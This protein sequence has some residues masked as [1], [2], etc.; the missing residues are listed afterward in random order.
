MGFGLAMPKPMT[1]IKYIED[2]YKNIEDRIARIRR[3]S[4]V[5]I[6][7]VGDVEPNELRT[8]IRRHINARGGIYEMHA[9]TV[10]NVRGF[11]VHCVER[12]PGRSVPAPRKNT[13]MA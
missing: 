6:P 9:G 4:F 8:I 10:K 5:F 1:R 7:C 11:W 2:Q 12:V 13:C 3:D